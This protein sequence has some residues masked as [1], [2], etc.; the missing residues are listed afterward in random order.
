MIHKASGDGQGNADQ[1]AQQI[2]ILNLIDELLVNTYYDR[3]Q[4]KGSTKISRDK[5]QEMLG[6]ETWMKPSEAL[7]YGFIDNVINKTDGSALAKMAAL[8]NPNKNMKHLEKLKALLAGG[9]RTELT[10]EHIKTAVTSALDGRKYS[11]INDE[12][13]A[14][15]LGAV[16]G[17]LEKTVGGTLT[18]AEQA[19]ADGL[20][21]AFI[22]ELKAQ[23]SSQSSQGQLDDIRKQIADL[24]NL[25]KTMSETVI[26]SG[27]QLEAV[28][29]DL[30]ETKKNI[31]TF[32][33]KPFSNDMGKI[34]LGD[35]YT[36]KD[37][38][39]IAR[40]EAIR[41]KIKETNK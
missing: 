36:P 18:E 38:G 41:N 31:R 25:V 33:K 3:N 7:A 6:A 22:T 19:V 35:G 21:N 11:E 1:L 30:T 20:L 16:K 13:G 15:F 23:E 40:M 26:A 27:A 39:H 29:F 17:L 12:N 37:P 14:A 8:F 5:V 32:G 10:A 24:A 4:A 2:E 34:S 9:G 28:A